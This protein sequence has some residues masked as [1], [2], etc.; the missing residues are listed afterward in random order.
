MGDAMLTDLNSKLGTTRAALEAAENRCRDLEADNT[1]VNA[2]YERQKAEL[3]QAMENLAIVEQM[4]VQLSQ[5][6]DARKN[7][8]IYVKKKKEELQKANERLHQLELETGEQK[9]AL[10]Q[11]DATIHHL[12]ELTD[13]LRKTI[14]TNLYEHAQCQSGLRAEIQRLKKFKG[15]DNDAEVSDETP[16][17]EL[18]SGLGNAPAMAPKG[19]SRKSNQKDASRQPRVSISAIDES[20][21]DTDWLV[22]SPA[23]VKGGAPDRDA[24]T[25]F[26]YKAPERKKTPDNPDQMLLF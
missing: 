17:G 22:A 1:K 4:Q 11:K 2:E 20:L 25:D 15:I 21:E 5:L 6:E 12:E 14:E 9:N 24:E 13:S 8:E 3:A 10:A 18:G 7:N 16:G 26:G 23:E 19:N